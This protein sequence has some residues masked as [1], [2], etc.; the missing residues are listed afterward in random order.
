MP[1]LERLTRNLV[2]VEETYNLKG[3]LIKYTIGGVE[4]KIPEGMPPRVVIYDPDPKA[5]TYGIRKFYTKEEAEKLE[6]YLLK[7]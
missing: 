2:T 6:Q 4:M 3:E 7:D 5:I 1:Q